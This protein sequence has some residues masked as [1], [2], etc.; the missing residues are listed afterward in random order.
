MLGMRES[1]DSLL[2]LSDKANGYASLVL[3]TSE[4]ART[5]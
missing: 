3:S 5:D 1:G 4:R 2:C